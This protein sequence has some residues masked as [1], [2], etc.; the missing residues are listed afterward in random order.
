MASGS[1]LGCKNAVEAASSFDNVTVIDSGHLS[2]GM[3]LLVLYAKRLSDG[4]MSVSELVER[5]EAARDR[6]ST[7]FIVESTDY[8]A[9]SGRL[10]RRVNSICAT[11]ML[12]PVIVL[13]NKGMHVGKIIMGTRKRMWRKYISDTLKHY[14]RVDLSVLYITYA[15]LEREELE[16]LTDLVNERLRFEKIVYQKASPAVSINCGPGCFGLLFMYKENAEETEIGAE[17]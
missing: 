1:S 5:I 4:D 6:V 14:K 11:L 10:G 13:K 8:L 7:S 16:E 2:S 17:E 3:G 15:G 12:H 9:R